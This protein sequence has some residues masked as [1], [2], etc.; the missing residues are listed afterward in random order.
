[1][2][3]SQLGL[4]GPRGLPCARDPTEAPSPSRCALWLLGA[5]LGGLEGARWVGGGHEEHLRSRSLNSPMGTGSALT[6]LR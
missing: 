6:S 5:P 3:A 1:M 4:Q 2:R